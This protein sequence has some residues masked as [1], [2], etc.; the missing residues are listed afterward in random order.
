VSH[1]VETSELVLLL[2]LLLLLLL[3]ERRLAVWDFISRKESGA[4][5][6]NVV[7]TTALAERYFSSHANTGRRVVEVLHVLNVTLSLRCQGV[8][9]RAQHILS[10]NLVNRCV[11]QFLFVG[12]LP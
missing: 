7:I 2:L 9:G 10:Q 4:L 6:K 3:P 11:R 1:S 5:T 12:Q 8:T